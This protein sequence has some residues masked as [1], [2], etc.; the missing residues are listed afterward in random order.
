MMKGTVVSANTKLVNDR[1]G[2]AV[3]Y[4]VVEIDDPVYPGLKQRVGV[5]HWLG[6]LFVGDK[7]ELNVTKSPIVSGT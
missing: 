4:L 6:D 5:S 1:T 2:G 7:V 3:Y